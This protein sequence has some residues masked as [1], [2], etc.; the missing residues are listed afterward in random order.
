MMQ[1]QPQQNQQHNS[2]H[3]QRF[4]QNQQSSGNQQQRNTNLS[5]GPNNKHQNILSEASD[6]NLTDQSMDYI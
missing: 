3:Q 5:A 2:N 6:H 4:Q 1:P